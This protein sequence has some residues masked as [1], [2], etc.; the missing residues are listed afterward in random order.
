MYNAKLPVAAI[1]F[2]PVTVPGQFSDFHRDMIRPGKV[3]PSLAH[4]QSYKQ[5]DEDD[6]LLFLFPAEADQRFG[7]QLA[8]QTGALGI[9][10]E[11][12]RWVSDLMPTP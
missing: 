8:S 5:R 7:P 1:P 3:S 10:S 11:E 6:N 9:G 12:L 4:L 2:P